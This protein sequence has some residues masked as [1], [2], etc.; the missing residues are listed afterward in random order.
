MYRESRRLSRHAVG[1]FPKK[2][3]KKRHSNRRAF[4]VRI[5]TCSPRLLCCCRRRHA[6]YVCFLNYRPSNVTP[7]SRRPFQ[8]ERS[9][10][11]REAVLLKHGISAFSNAADSI[12]W[13]CTEE[14]CRS[15]ESQRTYVSS[16]RVVVLAV[17]AT[18]S[19]FRDARIH[20]PSG[21]LAPALSNKAFPGVFRLR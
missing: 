1:E 15:E 2:C 6:G 14:A 7:G 17:S 8:D 16:T 12:K 10:S 4:P 3:A 11:R 18:R 20:G 9:A 21:A 13:L 19:L 5:A